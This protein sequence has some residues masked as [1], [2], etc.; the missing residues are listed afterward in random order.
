MVFHTVSR[1]VRILE[2]TLQRKKCP[3]WSNDGKDGH[4]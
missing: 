3:V 1:E 2:T 4:T